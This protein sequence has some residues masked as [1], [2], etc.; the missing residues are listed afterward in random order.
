MARGKWL[1]GAERE[2]I[3]ELQRDGLSIA[4]IAARVS[5]SYHFVYRHLRDKCDAKRAHS[6]NDRALRRASKR[7][8]MVEV[9]ADSPF[10]QLRTA[11]ERSVAVPTWTRL[12]SPRCE[13]LVVSASPLVPERTETAYDG[14][15][16]QD[17]L[18]AAIGDDDDSCEPIPFTPLRATR[19]ST[20]TF[21]HPFGHSPPVHT[22]RD[23]IAKGQLSPLEEMYDDEGLPA[24]G[25]F[26]Q[27]PQARTV[28]PTESSTLYLTWIGANDYAEE[29]AVPE[30]NAE[31]VQPA[32]LEAAAEPEQHF[33]D[34]SS[35]LSGL[36]S[37]L[38]DE[39]RRLS[40][41]HS[42]GFFDAQL[43]QLL[44]QFQADVLLLTRQRSSTRDSHTLWDRDSQPEVELEGQADHSDKRQTEM[45]PSW[46]PADDPQETA[47]G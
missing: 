43:L 18:G 44:I 27:A 6:E 35:D 10:E 2:R 37:S 19:S 11:S 33:A 5:R 47:R 16:A 42:I 31:Y 7:L 39:I 40:C 32:T 28:T 25:G 17:A 9:G 29:P 20:C 41:Q 30:Q 23:A 3:L 12:A 15:A 13:S 38:Q 1:S 21:P 34:R 4:A 14:A 45:L 22:L 8:K 26:D 46:I 24:R 36:H